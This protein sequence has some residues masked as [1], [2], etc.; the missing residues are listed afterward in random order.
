MRYTFAD[1]VKAA[2]AIDAVE[3]MKAE[4]AEFAAQHLAGDDV[5]IEFLEIASGDAF[6]VPPT[7]ALG[8]FKGKGLRPTFSYADM[9]GRANDQA[10]T[11]AKMLDVDLLAQVRTSL[12]AAMAN[13][14]PFGE[15]R[16]ELEPILRAAGWW[17]KGPMPDPITGQV[18]NAQLGSAWRLET[19]FRTNLQ[20]AYAAGQWQEIQQQAELAPFLMYDAVDDFRTRDL[21][22]AWDGKVLPVNSPW[23]RTH[24]PPNGWNCRCGVIQLDAEQL[25]SM[26]ITPQADPPSDGFYSWTNPR[27]GETIRVPNGLD[28]GFDR[29]PGDTLQG[30]LRE[31]LR[32]K[33]AVL[34]E[35]MQAAIAP[36]LRRQF[37]TTTDAGRW[38]VASFE[39]SPEWLREKVLDEQRV[40][41]EAGAGGAFAIGGTVIN[42][43][44]YTPAAAQGQSVW[45]HEFGHIL[46]ARN[47]RTALYR[48]A[49]DDFRAAQKEDGDRLAAAAGNGRKSKANDAL[50]ASVVKAYE[51]ARTRIIDADR[52]DRVQVLRDMADAAGVNLARLLTVIDESTK[53]ME[54]GDWMRDLGL[55]V[56]IARMIEALRLGDGE[57]FVRL[58]VVKDAVEEAQRAGRWDKEAQAFTSA[59]WKK[60]GT[61]A[62]LSDLIGSATKNRAANHG[63]GFSGHSNAYYA[64]GTHFAPTESFANLTDLAGHPNSY[65]WEIAQRLA[66]RMSALYR[67]IIEGSAP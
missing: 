17:G 42:M 39:Q 52:A 66:P 45:R 28:P 30:E 18:V 37:D 67:Q 46:D 50:R 20:T 24:Y 26:G 43:G 40:R 61:V 7:E 27:T 33:V 60:D 13:G 14:T 47:G 44:K 22:R 59:S 16:R 15:W 1:L 54:F 11:V 10:F 19:I 53:L 8:Y 41:V 12:D 3:R 6:Q 48:S 58:A 56:R 57:G 62:S 63:D 65:W 2:Q 31:L 55:Q 49:Q 5:V 64:K 32:E 9:I 21:H 34:P 36:V 25:A 35:D 23:W 4:L 51:D 29:N 38:H